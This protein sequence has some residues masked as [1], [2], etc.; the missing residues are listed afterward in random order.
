MNKLL[1]LTAVTVLIALLV[2]NTKK[3]PKKCNVCH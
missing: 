3:E 1:L 2:L